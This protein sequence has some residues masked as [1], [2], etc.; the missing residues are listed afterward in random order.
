MTSPLAPYL[1]YDWKEIDP[2]GIVLVLVYHN[3]TE[4]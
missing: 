1:N 4:N 2:T 3:I